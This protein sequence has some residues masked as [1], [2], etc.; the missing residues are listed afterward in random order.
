MVR[1]KARERESIPLFISQNIQAKNTGVGHPANG[2]KSSMNK[3]G[4]FII[5]QGCEKE[6]EELGQ[7]RIIDESELE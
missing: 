1:G 3:K 2:K 6:L 5:S 4:L 7:T